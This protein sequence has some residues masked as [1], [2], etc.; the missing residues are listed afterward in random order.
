[1]RQSFVLEGSDEV[2]D[3]LRS[4]V[5]SADVNRAVGAAAE[6]LSERVRENTPPGYSKNLPQSVLFSAIDDGEYLIGYDRGVE[7]AG[8]PALDS[9]MRPRTR[10]RSVMAAS[11]REWVGADALASVLE[12]T[13]TD[14]AEDS[15][16][17]VAD[18]ISGSVA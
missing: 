2:I 4:S 14:Y 12:Q 9:V 6:W 3:S 18:G 5:D 13:F 10:G 17:I 15:V 11:R 1:M 8:D 16:R 7:T